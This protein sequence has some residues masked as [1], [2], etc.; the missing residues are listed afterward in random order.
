MIVV[1][2]PLAIETLAKTVERGKEKRGKKEEKE[3]TRI[4][5]RESE[6]NAS[7]NILRPLSRIIYIY[8]Y[9]CMCVCIYMIYSF[10]FFFSVN[11]HVY[12]FLNYMNINNA[13]TWNNNHY[14]APLYCIQ[15]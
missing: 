10:L 13:F 8:I 4:R 15:Y 2:F 12:I 1:C 5:G 7:R 9:R 6:K 11:V 14:I 3:T